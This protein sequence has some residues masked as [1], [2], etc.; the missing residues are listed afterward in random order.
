[1]LELRARHEALLTAGFRLFGFLWSSGSACRRL[2]QQSSR[3]LHRPWPA[4]LARASQQERQ[5]AATPVLA[6]GASIRVRS[7]RQ[8]QI[9][10]QRIQA[11]GPGALAALAAAVCA[12]SSAQAAT[13]GPF[14][15]ISGARLLSGET[16]E[17][18]ATAETPIVLKNNVSK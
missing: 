6:A 9:E 17:V 5:C 16:R 2:A 13:E 3:V 11:L 4:P 18:S 14:Y 1:M 15:K 10:M 12:T 7:T 8:E